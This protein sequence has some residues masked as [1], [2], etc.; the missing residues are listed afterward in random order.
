MNQFLHDLLSSGAMIYVLLFFLLVALVIFAERFLY[1]HRARVDTL[2]LL[3]GLMVQLRN[4]NVKEA[5]VNCDPRT[6]PV[7]EIFRAAIEHWKDGER[8]VRFAIEETVRLLI[9]RLERNLK[10]LSA[11]A[12]MAPVI[13]LLGTLFA[14]IRLFGAMG[15]GEGQFPGIGQLL[16]S[17]SSALVCTAVGLIVFLVCQFFHAVLVEKVDRQLSEMGKG[18]AEITFFLANHPAPKE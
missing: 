15:T 13:G 5:I 10:L 4:G 8:G 17:I 6:G 3:R 2:E 16:P 14:L 12:N 11:L 18:A 7:G 1:L 9:P